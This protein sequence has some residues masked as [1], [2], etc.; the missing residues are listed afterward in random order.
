MSWKNNYTP[1]KIERVEELE[2]KFDN[3]GEI[4][5]DFYH[6]DHDYGQTLEEI[7]STVN[8]M[9]SIQEQVKLLQDL[10]SNDTY[11]ERIESLDNKQGIIARAENNLPVGYQRDFDVGSLWLILED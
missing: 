11:T 10:A 3:N 8:Q 4:R 2:D 7:Q 9:T 5:E 6:F 1:F